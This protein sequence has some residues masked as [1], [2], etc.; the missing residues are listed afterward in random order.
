MINK[1]SFSI[2]GIITVIF[3]INVLV[4]TTPTEAELNQWVL[5]ENGIVCKNGDGNEEC[6]KDGQLPGGSSSHFRNAGIFTSH[7]KNFTFENG[8]KIT[9]RTLGILGNT[10]KMKDGTLWDTLN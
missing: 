7:E 4:F 3:L 10:I 1:K 8:E 9:F 2:A 6:T 5:K